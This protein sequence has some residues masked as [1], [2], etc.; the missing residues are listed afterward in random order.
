MYRKLCRLALRPQSQK[1]FSTSTRCVTVCES[2]MRSCSLNNITVLPLQVSHF[3]TKNSKQINPEKT[4]EQLKKSA[5]EIQAYFK[6][7]ET[8]AETLAKFLLDHSDRISLSE[9]KKTVKWL[10]RMRATFP[11]IYKN[12]HL[13]L[14][15]LSKHCLSD[16]IFDFIFSHMNVL[17]QIK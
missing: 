4:Q 13:L 6:C 9:V 5:A 10:I 7:S 12:I 3:S 8:E 2:A 16:T 15:P 14:V 11:V 17:F 1:I